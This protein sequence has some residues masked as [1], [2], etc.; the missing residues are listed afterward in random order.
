MSLGSRP[1]TNPPS[2]NPVIDDLE[3]VGALTGARVA[4]RHDRGTDR[5]RAQQVRR[6]PAGGLLAR[7]LLRGRAQNHLPPESG[8]IDVF[9][10]HQQP[11]VRAQLS[12]VLEGVLSQ[13]LIP[14]ADGRG[15]VLALEIMA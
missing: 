5:V 13:A 1:A 9:P 10:P 15:L 11:Q 3:R 14:R 2:Y 4:H 12:L 7:P 8:P 6:A